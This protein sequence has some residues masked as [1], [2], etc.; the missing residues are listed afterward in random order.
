MLKHRYQIYFILGISSFIFLCTNPITAHA[1]VD[2]SVLKALIGRKI[3]LEK[4]DGSEVRGVLRGL[5]GKNVV[6]EKSNGR[7]IRLLI[8]SLSSVKTLR[9]EPTNNNPPPA[10]NEPP[11]NDDGRRPMEPPPNNSG[12][13]SQPGPPPRSDIAYL[14]HKYYRARK[15][16]NRGI[17]FIITGIIL[18]ITG[19]AMVPMSYN[20]EF[21]SLTSVTVGLTGVVFTGVGIPFW[22]VGQIRKGRTGRRLRRARRNSRRYSSKIVPMPPQGKLRTFVTSR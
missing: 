21:M 8:S 13:Y 19:A 16:R 9:S 12:R 5:S 20:N 3:L 7:V 2:S 10:S 4:Q 6:V 17:G 22:I 1:S 11:I 18:M 14:Q 15:L